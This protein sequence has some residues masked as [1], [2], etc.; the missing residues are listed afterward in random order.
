MVGKFKR[1]QFD[2]FNLNLFLLRKQNY[3]LFYEKLIFVNL[4]LN[5]GY[6]EYLVAPL[7]LGLL[8]FLKAKLFYN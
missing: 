5:F 7:G 1:N 4:K 6:I 3:Y 8:R 2:P